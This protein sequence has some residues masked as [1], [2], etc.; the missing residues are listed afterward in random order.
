MTNH[1]VP[2]DPIM[3]C[4]DISNIQFTPV[5]SAQQVA[6]NFFGGAISYWT[7][8]DMAD[9]G[10]LPCIWKGRRPFFFLDSLEQ[11]RH[12]QQS[13]P[14]WEQRARQKNKKSNVKE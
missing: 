2:I 5:L 12:E 3:P 6:T 8:L 9:E 4:K 1:Y 10:E 11:W 14:V 13:L 7:V